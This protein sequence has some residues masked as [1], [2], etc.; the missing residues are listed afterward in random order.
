MLPAARA[1]RAV[2]AFSAM[3]A[4]GARVT[5]LA[6]IIVAADDGV[7]PQVG[8]GTLCCAALCCAVLLLCR[9]VLRCAAL[10]CVVAWG[11]LRDACEVLPSDGRG[12]GL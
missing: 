1:A 9:S 11:C 10:Y 7:R 4:R 6:I 8:P 5:D 2:Q 12:S 3:R